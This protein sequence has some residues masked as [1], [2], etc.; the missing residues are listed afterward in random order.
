MTCVAPQGKGESCGVRGREKLTLGNLVANALMACPASA[1]FALSLQAH[2]RRY[3]AVAR[4]LVVFSTKGWPSR[5]VKVPVNQTL[6]AL[7]CDAVRCMPLLQRLENKSVEN[8]SAW[9]QM[10]WR[11]GSLA[12]A[13]DA[14]DA[15]HHVTH[16]REIAGMACV[17]MLQMDTGVTDNLSSH[18]GQI[19]NLEAAS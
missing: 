12:A 6:R 13:L 15:T 10:G 8:K 9:A 3:C 16:A 19:A 7:E 1:R 14:Q 2:L 17:C 4:A 11:R 18:N 5:W